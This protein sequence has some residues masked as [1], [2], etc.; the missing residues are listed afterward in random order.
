MLNGLIELSQDV[1]GLGAREMRLADQIPASV[2]CKAGEAS[3][4]T[5][6]FSRIDDRIAAGSR[7]FAAVG[8]QCCTS[9]Q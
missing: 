7:W 6:I 9:S 1:I 3:A 2:S 4:H 5:Q 8:L